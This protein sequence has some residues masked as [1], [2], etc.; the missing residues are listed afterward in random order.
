M[1]S[2]F[3][4]VWARIKAH[5]GHAFETKT[6]RPFTFEVAG[7]S[8]VPSRTHYQIGRG[9]F[10]KAWELFP[11]D[12]PGDISSKVRGSAYVWAILHDRRIARSADE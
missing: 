7:N 4:P 9:D 5:A 3:D 12:G 1:K 11:L 2:A 10:E 6:G 8:V